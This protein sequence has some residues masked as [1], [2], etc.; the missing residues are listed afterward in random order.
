[1]KTL[2]EVQEYNLC[3]GWLNNWHD[4]NGPSYFESREAAQNE[5]DE[6]L[7]DCLDEVQAGNMPDS[8][9]SEDFRIVEV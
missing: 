2:Y 3:G 9:D 4:E 1:M 6:F 7:A 8:P 5:L